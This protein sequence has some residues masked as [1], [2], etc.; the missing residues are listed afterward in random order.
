M[1]STITAEKTRSLS[2]KVAPQKPDGARLGLVR[3][4]LAVA[5]VFVA[6]SWVFFT[7]LG[8]VPLFNPDECF[9]AEPAREMLDTGDFITTTLNYD[10]RY[11]KP[12]LHYWATA[13]CYHLFG[14]DEFAARF[15]SAVCAAVLVTATYCL[16]N[17]LVG[18]RAAF[19]STAIILTSPLFVVTGRLAIA[20]M[21]LSLFITGGLYCFFTAFREKRMEFTWLGYVLLSCAMMTKGPVGIVLPVIILGVYH[22]LRRNFIEAIKFYKPHWGA[23]LAA[24]ISLPW[25]VI[26]TIV[27]KGEYFTCF[28]VMENFQ[29]FTNSVSG[30]KAPW[31]Y[32]LVA[33]G[34]G[35]LPWSV[36]IP[37]SL[38]AAAKP[39]QTE[40]TSLLDTYRVLSPRQDLALFAACIAVTTVVFYSAS[41]S[42]LLSYTVPCFPAFAMLMAIEVDRR[43]NQGQLKHLLIPF[44]ILATVYGVGIF[45][46]L[47][48]VNII[49]GV[50]S[51]IS[52]IVTL[53]MTI[54]FV[55][56]AAGIALIKFKKRAIG[57]A[58]IGVV[59]LFSTT[60]LGYQILTKVTDKNERGLPELAQF[61][62]ASQDPIF[63]YKVRLPSATFYT[64]RALEMS[65]AQERPIAGTERYTGVA[66]QSQPPKIKYFGLGEPPAAQAVP[67]T[68]LT[69]YDRLTGAEVDAE[70]SKRDKAYVISKINDSHELEGRPGYK[71]VAQSGSFVLL[72]WL[73]P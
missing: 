21:S 48:V 2:P 8:D 49:R 45:A 30:H 62:G 4:L 66:G 1:V 50:P 64:R 12:P 70:V 25:Y 54:Q 14:P 41:V 55:A 56:F 37:Q 10:I 53:Y 58:V 60:I 43:L 33:V 47:P 3:E 15:F 29:R 13:L 34:L 42:K 18:M 31:T 6:S 38:F 69:S 46:A 27:T 9:Y 59:T 36:L 67:A 40:K 32:H 7:A 44:G 61:A 57:A 73:K 5:L 72:R 28:I 51:G 20:D 16:V 17:K 35:L 63:V 65:P 19:I 22:L 24:A 26:E 11:T 52:E 39:T 23:L 71:R 68:P